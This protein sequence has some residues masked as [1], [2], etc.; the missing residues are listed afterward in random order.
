MIANLDPTTQKWKN[1]ED[2]YIDRGIADS[3]IQRD[4]F[5]LVDENIFGTAIFSDKRDYFFRIIDKVDEHV[6]HEK[7]PA[8]EGKTSFL[9]TLSFEI[10]N[11]NITKITEYPRPHPFV[12]MGTDAA[13]IEIIK[14]KIDQD[15]DR[16]RY[17]KGCVELLN[18]R[19]KIEELRQLSQKTEYL[20]RSLQILEETEK[21]NDHSGCID[22]AIEHLTGI[23]FY[24][25]IVLEISSDVSQSYWD[26]VILKKRQNINQ[27]GRI[28]Q[29]AYNRYLRERE[30]IDPGTRQS[31]SMLADIPIT[32]R[33]NRILEYTHMDTFNGY[34]LSK[35]NS[36]RTVYDLYILQAMKGKP[37]IL[38]KLTKTE[39]MAPS[40]LPMSHRWINLPIQQST[41]PDP[42]I[43]KVLESF[44][45]FFGKLI[46]VGERVGTNKQ[47]DYS[48]SIGYHEYDT[49]GLLHGKTGFLPQL[50]IHRDISQ[51][52]S[53]SVTLDRASAYS[54]LEKGIRDPH[55]M[56]N[57]ILKST[58]NE[59]TDLSTF[60]LH[61]KG[62][63]DPRIPSMIQR[64]EDIESTMLSI[65]QQIE[66]HKART[67]STGRDFS[68]A[69]QERMSRWKWW[70]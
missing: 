65:E 70:Q 10:S 49:Q 66:E 62:V 42:N 43:R 38:A 12:W 55:I 13:N 31:R 27:S 26:K 51:T 59:D 20:K 52:P 28:E 45:S 47:L 24:E 57:S 9:T 16:I 64:K 37:T 60:I 48:F 25:P 68:S 69:L 22:M 21:F 29:G 6:K 32:D 39:T 30:Y 19:R 11:Q 63:H 50:Y 54:M 5:F 15:A 34:R 56:L 67:A 3:D 36:D 7:Q 17:L 1:R 23:R 53:I 14:Y 41:P 44:H 46:D 40:Q 4:T 61:H 35:N 33:Q 58:L 2:Y 18:D 8:Y